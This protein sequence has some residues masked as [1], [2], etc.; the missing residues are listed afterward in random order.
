MARPNIVPALAVSAGLLGLAFVIPA[1]SN[2]KPAPPKPTPPKTTPGVDPDPTIVLDEL[3]Y[4]FS[5]AVETTSAARVL[6]AVDV[7][8]GTI[9]KTKGNLVIDVVEPWLNARL[10][11]GEAVYV[12]PAVTAETFMLSL[13]PVFGFRRLVRS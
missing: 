12:S 3:E 13:D 7:D 1:N 6:R 5:W 9:F 4:A 10:D 8:W 11:A 2:A